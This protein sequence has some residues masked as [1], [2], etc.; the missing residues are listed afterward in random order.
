MILTLYSIIAPLDAFEISS[1]W[2][3]YG[4]WIFHNTF[5]SIQNMTSILLN[6]FNVV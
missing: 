5:K 1:I 6:F 2:K 3:Y 4:K